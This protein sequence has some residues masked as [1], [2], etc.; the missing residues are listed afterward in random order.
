MEWH[1]ADGIRWLGAKLPGAIAVF[2]TRVG[3]ASTGDYAG[4]NLG[5]MTDDEATVVRENR[6]RLV[7]ALG[8]EPADVALGF[9]VHGSRVMRHL[10]RQAGCPY[11]M[12]PPSPP[13]A[14]G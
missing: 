14:D 9:Q 4:L 5:F 11:L 8:R 2:T 12:L 3:G 10:K 6:M 1:E 7:A 13:E